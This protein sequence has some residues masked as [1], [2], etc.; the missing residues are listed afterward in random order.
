MCGG[1]A[2]LDV[3]S[4]AVT[5]DGAQAELVPA[6]PMPVPVDALADELARARVGDAGGA[7]SALRDRLPTSSS[8]GTIVVF[9]RGPI[10]ALPD[11]HAGRRERFAELDAL[12]AGWQVELRSRPGAALVEAQFFSP[13]G[14]LFKSFAEARRAGLKARDA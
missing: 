3:L 1:S 4:L 7:P 13:E 11:E 6:A 8:G 14:M 9:P 12:Q 10:R 5:D 2:R